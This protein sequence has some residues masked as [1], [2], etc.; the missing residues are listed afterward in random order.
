MKCPKC[1]R[2]QYYVCTNPKCICQNSV[3][4]NKKPQTWVDDWS[5][6]C[7]YCGFVA[8]DDYWGEREMR[9]AE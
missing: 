6:R 2:K 9:E 3:P 5:L 8:S 4:K 1:Q 7:P